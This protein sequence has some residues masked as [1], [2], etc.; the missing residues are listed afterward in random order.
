[1]SKLEELIHNSNQVHDN[2][3]DYSLIKEFTKMKD[4]YPIICPS[5][6]VFYKSFEKHIHSKQGCPMCSGRFRYDTNSFI[7]TVSKLNHCVDYSFEKTIYVNNK[8]KVVVTCKEHGDFKISPSHLLNGQ[9]C[10]KCRYIKSAN[11]KRRSIDD[12]IKLAKDVHGD[13]YDYSLIKAYKNDRIKYP[14]ICPDHGVFEQTFNNHINGRQG[15]PEC[16]KLKCAKSRTLSFEECVNKA[17]L[18]HN[19][20]Y[21]YD[22]DGFKN[23]DSYV[24][25]H[26]SKHGVFR[27]Q[28]KNHLIGQ[29]CPLCFKEKSNVEQQVLDLC[30]TLVGEENIICN[31]RTIL[32][33]KE[34]DIYIPS[35]NIAIEINGLIW[36]S[37]KFNK[38]NAYHAKKTELCEKQGIRLIHIFEDE[39][40]FNFNII[41]SRL[42]HLFGVIDN[43]IY[44]RKCIIKHI[45]NKISK[46]FINQNHIQGYTNSQYNI[47][48]Y[49]NDELVSVMSFC[50]Q[51]INVGR[52]SNTN[53]WELLRFCNKLNTTVV[54]G[55]SKL[56]KFFIKEI[57]P[58]NIISYADRRWSNGNL[59][60][61]LKFSLSHISKPSYFYI[62]VKPHKRVNR[63]NLRKNILVEKYNCPIDISEHEFCLSKGWYRI[64]DCGC[65]CYIW[66]KD[67]EV[68]N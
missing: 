40:E 10:P 64:Y 29:K 45:N 52:K 13:K 56:L 67:E 21:T 50:K 60:E 15:C 66:K 8:T 44:A 61:K 4:K 22:S 46:E 1:M 9:G 54:G 14:I 23:T 65:L 17:N 33:G 55:A 36:H 42:M 48:L 16:G 59:Y 26:C 58:E 62:N 51:R 6:G 19:F 27:Q 2:K 12:V 18:V 7:E 38:D 32:G 20:A 68:N 24:N 43:K 53:E 34:L 47:G 41:K 57:N 28:M 63:F 35:K 31:D 3:Y 37:E 39:I 5:H 25:I 49:Y 30:K 11:S